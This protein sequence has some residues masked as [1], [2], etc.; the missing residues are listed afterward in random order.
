[1]PTTTTKYALNLS[2]FLTGLTIQ[3]RDSGTYIAYDPASEFAWAQMELIHE[4]ERQYNEGKPVRIIVLKARQLGISTISAG[5]VFLWSF[6]RKGTTGLI[7]AHESDISQ[8]LFEKTQINWENWPF[9]P[10][11]TPKNMSM[12]RMTWGETHSTI[13]IASAKNVKSGRGRTIHILHG[14]ECAYWDEAETL[15][16]GLNQ[17]IPRSHGTIVIMESTANGVGGWFYDEWHKA[18][19]GESDFIPLFFPWFRHY[20]YSLPAYTVD[21]NRLSRIEKNLLSLGATKE[22]L[23]WRRWAIKNLCHND[24]EYFKQEYPATP[25]EAF[26][27]SGTN[28][29]PAYHLQQC[30]DQKKGA[31]GEIILTPSG[32]YEFRS[33][34]NGPFTMFRTPSAD[35]DWGQYV[36]AGDPTHTT[37]GDRACIQVLSARTFE[38]VGV[39]HGHIDPINF[40]DELMKLGYYYNT[41]TVN[42]EVDGPG[43]ATVGRLTSMGYPKLWQHRWADKSPGK[44]STVNL[45]WLSNYQRKHW[46]INMVKWLLSEESILIHDPETHKQMRDYAVLSD[47]GAMGNGSPRGFDDAVMAL[48]IAVITAMTDRA[49]SYD[50]RDITKSPRMSING[51]ELIVGKNVAQFSTSDYF[52]T[53]PWD[54]FTEPNADAV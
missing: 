9:A 50:G 53:P 18:V 54:A 13:K 39:W 24:E 40:A 16:V 3:D 47:V 34:P 44:I 7:I 17:T 28:V 49:A 42:T 41:A 46:A 26:L 22:N 45:G 37:F 14:S 10:L 11:Y 2:P 30:Y 51:R 29:F 31:V 12:S 43:Y 21:I 5:L 33:S 48:A 4:V 25:E 20:Q 15:M 8:S 36:V 38:Q 32:K 23:E 27:T 1:M 6:I 35:H 19:A 52:G